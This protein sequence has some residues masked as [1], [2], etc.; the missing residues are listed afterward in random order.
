MLEH[1]SCH[2]AIENCL[3]DKTFA[4]AKLYKEEKAMDMTTNFTVS[5]LETYL[6]LINTKVIN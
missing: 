3:K 1:S 4:I 5:L 2:V 6:S